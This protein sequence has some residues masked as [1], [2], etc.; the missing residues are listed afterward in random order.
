MKER[1]EI[2]GIVGGMGPAATIQFMHLVVSLTP[3]KCDQDHI[4]MLVDMN[5]A[6]PDRTAAILGQGPSPVPELVKSAQLLEQ[7]GATFLVFP[8]N[9]AHYF[10]PQVQPQISIP[11]LNMIEETAAYIKE[12]G[13][14]KIALLATDGTVQTGIYQQ[15]LTSRDLSCLVPDELA[16]KAVMKT[17]YDIKSG[18]ELEVAKQTFAPAINWSKRQGAE[19]VI[20]GCTELSLILTADTYQG[21]KVIDAMKVVAG[22]VLERVLD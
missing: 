8:C 2:L 21:L 12:Q 5:P 7:A 16:Q 14:K 13:I 4:R 18:C 20:A 9:T 17:I 11:I 6:I 22:K 19:A 3:A 10:L 15:A 1:K